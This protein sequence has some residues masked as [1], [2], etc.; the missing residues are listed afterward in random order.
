MSLETTFDEVAAVLNDI[1]GVDATFIP[2]TG[3]PVSLKAAPSGD[4]KEMPGDLSA[5]VPGLT[6]RFELLY[7]DLGRLPL[8]GEKLVVDDIS[9]VIDSAD[10][11]QDERFVE[12][13]VRSG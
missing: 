13:I 2:R 7:S 9:Y 3:D 6:K 10:N 4:F 5:S 12:V 8:K 11:Q 1:W